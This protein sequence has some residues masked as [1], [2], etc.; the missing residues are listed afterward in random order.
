M[1]TTTKGTGT[2]ARTVKHYQNLASEAVALPPPLAPSLGRV[3]PWRP[4]SPGESPEALSLTPF[5]FERRVGAYLAGTEDVSMSELDHLAW[6]AIGAFQAQLAR[7][8]GR[9][10]APERGSVY[11]LG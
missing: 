7:L 4:H 3:I 8:H 2:K 1:N 11:D 9:P 5:E 6:S 10:R